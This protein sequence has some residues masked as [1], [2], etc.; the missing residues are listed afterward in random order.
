M[1]MAIRLFSIV[2]SAVLVS[3]QS[4]AGDVTITL[5]NGTTNSLLVTVYDMNVQPPL[6]ILS[7]ALINDNAS[8]TVSITLDASG[9]GKVAWTATTVDRD[10]R[11]CGSGHKSNLND[12]DSV[13]V[14]TDYDCSGQ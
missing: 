7:S 9:Q 2:V 14:N 11:A 13:D 3:A 1:R 6:K 5:N 8:I 12:G 10:M 4:F